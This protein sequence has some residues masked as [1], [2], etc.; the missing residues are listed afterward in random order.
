MDGAVSCHRDTRRPPQRG[1]VV[2]VDRPVLGASN[3]PWMFAEDVTEI[4]GAVTIK[5]R[6]IWQMAV[7]QK[8]GGKRIKHVKAPSVPSWQSLS[9]V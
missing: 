5:Q 7:G 4:T 6:T 1:L 8:I 9:R 3:V 2:P